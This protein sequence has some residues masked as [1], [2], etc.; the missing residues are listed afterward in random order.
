VPTDCP[1][2][3]CTDVYSRCDLCGEIGRVFQQRGIDRCGA[4]TYYRCVE[5]TACRLRRE[6][7]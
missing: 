5:I 3:G 4:Y 7:A 2:V 6:A 1:L